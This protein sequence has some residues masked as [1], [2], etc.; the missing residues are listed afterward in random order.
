LSGKSREVAIALKF[1]K[2]F[3]VVADAD[4]AQNFQNRRARPVI[5]RDCPRNWFV[6]ADIPVAV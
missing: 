5:L 1:G 6:S 4:G 3:L 2:D